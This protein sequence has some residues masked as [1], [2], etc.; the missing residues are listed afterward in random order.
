[1]VIPSNAGDAA[2]LLRTAFICGGPVLFCEAVALYNRRDWEGYNILSKY[3]PIEQLAPFGKAKI[4]NDSARDITIISYG[5]TLPMSLRAAQ[6]LSD[7]GINCRVIDLR[8]V[9]P[10]DW[11]TISAAVKECGKALIVSE[12][13]FYGGV[14]PTLAA[15]IS[16]NL[17]DYLDAPVRLL[18]AQ[19]CRVAYG[20]D[21][22]AICL[23]QT[24]NVVS[25]ALDLAGY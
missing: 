4:Y 19:D 8:T 2:A 3:P 22:D 23:P 21:G 17:F 7:K 14:G 16:D 6:I 15:Y 9:K 25:A 18:H 13:R 11:E 24:D 1:V 5:I 10:I 20:L 12:D